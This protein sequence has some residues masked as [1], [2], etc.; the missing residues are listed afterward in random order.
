MSYD[1]VYTA[2]D[3]GMSRA[4]TEFKGEART[5][6][7]EAVRAEERPCEREECPDEKGRGKCGGV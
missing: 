1:T 2:R 3:K 4:D 5:E 7:V 6:G